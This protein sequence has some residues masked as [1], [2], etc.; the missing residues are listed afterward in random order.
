MNKNKI[1]IVSRQNLTDLDNKLISISSRCQNKEVRDKIVSLRTRIEGQ[2]PSTLVDGLDLENEIAEILK[3]VETDV[4]NQSYGVAGMRL[5]KVTILLD[6]RTVFAPEEKLAATKQ[7]Q[8]KQKLSDKVMQKRLKKRKKLQKQGK[9][10]VSTYTDKELW[11]LYMQKL[12]DE[13]IK[14]ENT[15]Q[16]LSGKDDQI[17]KT[18]L[19]EAL[20]N[21]KTYQQE[22]ADY[23]NEIIR[24]TSIASMQKMDDNYKS[25]IA[26]RK[27]SSEEL[28]IIRKKH[29]ELMRQRGTDIGETTDLFNDAMSDTGATTTTSN[30]ATKTTTGSVATGSTASGSYTSAADRIINSSEFSD[31][32]GRKSAEEQEKEKILNDPDGYLQGVNDSIAKLDDMIA[33]LNVKYNNSFNKTR[34]LLIMLQNADPADKKALKD[35]INESDAT[36]AGIEYNRD[37]CLNKKNKLIENRITLEKIKT[38]QTLK[39]LDSKGVNNDILSD[40]AMGIVKSIEQSNEDLRDAGTVNVVI[41]DTKIETESLSGARYGLN[42]DEQEGTD[43]HLEQLYKKYNVK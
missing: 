34:E 10:A 31:I 30:T 6:S 21:R 8:K 27:V 14:L 2:A 32:T 36:C 37:R 11:Y 18:M 1:K 12:S 20:L 13:V 17:S 24:D 28:E 42:R 35:K 7:D 4:L 39:T 19:A 16:S 22:I 3:D 15:I 5:D 23:S 38:E 41:D 26:K 40:L 43:D 25:L 29:A 33:E 9:D